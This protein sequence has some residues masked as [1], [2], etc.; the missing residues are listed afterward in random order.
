MMGHV[1]FTVS[2]FLT[3]SCGLPAG[4]RYRN[5]RGRAL[6]NLATLDD[7]RW[8][9]VASY[10]SHLLHYVRFDSLE[11]D[12]PIHTPIHTAIDRVDDPY[13]ITPGSC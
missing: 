2:R 12:T 9:L 7:S 10:S 5:V 6:R 3:V 1:F 4:K 11:T 13:L 8:W